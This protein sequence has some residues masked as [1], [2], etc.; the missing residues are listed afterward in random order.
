MPTKA[1]ASSCLQIQ[2]HSTTIVSVAAQM[3]LVAVTNVCS[4][5]SDDNPVTKRLAMNKVHASV[6]AARGVKNAHNLQVDGGT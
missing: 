3:T 6:G 2:G 5:A 1:G 4:L